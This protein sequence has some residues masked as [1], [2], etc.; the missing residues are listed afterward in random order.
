MIERIKIINFK[1]ISSKEFFF[2][3]KKNVIIWENWVWKTNVLQ[4]IWLLFWNNLFWNNFQNFVKKTENLFYIEWD[5]FVDG[6]KTTLS[7]SYDLNENKKVYLLNK[8]KVSKKVFLENTLKV[9]SF[10]PLDMNLFYLWPKYRRDF[11][12]QVI[13][14]TFLEYSDLLK[15][16]E[17]ILKS[18]NKLLK[19]ICEWKSKKEEIYFWDEKF[20]TLASEI[21]KYR[22]NLVFYIKENIKSNLDIFWIKIDK[23]DFIYNTKIDLE[24]IEKYIE[25]YLNKN[26]DRDI[27]IWK[28]QV[29]PHL[30]DFSILLDDTPI[31]EYASRWEIKSIVIILKLLEISYIEKNTWK[32]TIFLLDDLISE[33][34]NK[35]INILLEKL[36]ELQLIITSISDI[37]GINENNIFI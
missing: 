31:I 24:N 13:S 25:D 26:L 32:K 27:L 17:K 5:F 1:W 7:L 11:L 4:A 22:I 10:L 35:H 36:W 28:T 12:D 19:N 9:S 34:D 14:T 6:F 20:I 30:D 3:A 33:L 21:I 37:E 15:E 18:R 23:I 16:Y 8:K 29:W 2:S